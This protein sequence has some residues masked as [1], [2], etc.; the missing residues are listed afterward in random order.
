M[1]IKKPELLAPAG[2]FEK[3]KTA[4]MYGADAVYAG[5]PTLSL[6]ARA[7][8][9]FSD[10]ENTIKYAKQHGKQVYA[11]V[12]IFAYDEQYEDIKNAAIKLNELEVDGIIAADPGVIKQ[13]QKYAP[14]IPINISTQANTIS[15]H[16]CNFW[17]DMGAKRII[18]G[19]EVSKKELK[20]I[21]E[22]KHE[23][24]EIE[25]F[26]HGAICFAY[27]G[28]CFLSDFLCNRSANLGDCAQSCRWNYNVYVEEHNNPGEL[29]PVEQEDRGM[30]IF[31]SK[32][33]CLLKELPEIMYMGVDSL[34]IEGRLKTEYYLA[35]VVNAYRH[36][37]D[38][39]YEMFKQGLSLE[40]V[41]KVHEENI[42]KYLDEI[43]KTKTR[44]LTTFYF[45][46]KNN[47]DTQDYTG[48]QYNL[49]YEF[50]GIVKEY[51]KQTKLAFVE[52]K[53]K[54][55]VGDTLE[56]LLPNK[57]ESAR[58]Q[59]KELYD[60]DTKE[61]IETVNPGVKG[62]SVYIKIDIGEDIEKGYIL[63]RKL[64]KK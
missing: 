15:Y 24:L 29:M 51:N 33:M 58:F 35:T 16:T 6:R 53:N 61:Q 27:S 49:D 22:N 39:I 21:M 5:T 48:R 11:A 45:N 19:R 17:H 31:S 62:Q 38:D 9:D 52:I 28:R 42:E 20:N 4:F 56:L 12:N 44:Q 14:N 8:L 55:T 34:K 26:V 50:G 47:M 32:D 40:E 1:K 18:L 36:A 7:K 63:R 25:I 57:L 3:V 23:D 60:Q 64:D 59:I 43:F 37:I 41:K 46:N 13:I 30:T 54:L 2:S 10:L